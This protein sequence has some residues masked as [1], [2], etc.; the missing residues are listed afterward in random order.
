MMADLIDE[1]TQAGYRIAGVHHGLVAG[2]RPVPGMPHHYRVVGVFCDA[3][4]WFARMR[5]TKPDPTNPT[6]RVESDVHEGGP[7]GDSL[8][9]AAWLG[10]CSSIP[11]GPEEV[12][13]IQ[14]KPAQ[15]AGAT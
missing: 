9:F 12:A 1:L 10:G 14:N 13:A 6:R 2:D 8:A 15:I 5:V 11:A 3:R 7:F 4:G